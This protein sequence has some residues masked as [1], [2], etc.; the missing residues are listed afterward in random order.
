MVTTNPLTRE[1]FARPTLQVARELIGKRLVRLEN[2]RRIAGYINEAEAYIGEEDQACHAR[3]GRTKRTEIMYGKPGFAYIYFTYGM[4]WLL[5]LVTEEAGFPAAVLI[6]S[7]WPSEGVDLIASRREGVLPARWTDGP[8]KI[9]QALNIDGSL[10]GIDVCAP[11][12][13]IFLEDGVSIPDSIVTKTPRVGLN[14]VP[15]P[16]KSLPWRFL[17]QGTALQ[18][19]LAED[20]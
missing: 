1:F 10:N 11:G 18:D 8:G 16:W 5:N 2:G 3:A 4:H 14:S 6:R 15:E 17:A 7:I 20:K 12:A 19:I 9:T 13:A